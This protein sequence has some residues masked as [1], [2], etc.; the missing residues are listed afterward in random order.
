MIEKLRMLLIGVGTER[1]G[2]YR[3]GGLLA[4]EVRLELERELTGKMPSLLL[5]HQIDSLADVFGHW[6]TG[7]LVEELEE[8]VLLGRDVHG[9][10]DLLPC[11]GETMHDHISN[12]NAPA[13]PRR[14]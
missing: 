5:Q 9:R 8:L 6:N 10:R 14:T 1:F 3:V 11:H 12:V 2:S 7:F 13:A 4:S